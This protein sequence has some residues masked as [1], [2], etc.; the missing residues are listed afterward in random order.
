MQKYE[1]TYGPKQANTILQKPQ[2][3][4]SDLGYDWHPSLK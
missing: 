1:T 3:V 2:H 4:S